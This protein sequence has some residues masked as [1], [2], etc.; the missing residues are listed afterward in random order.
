[1]FLLNNQYL[2]IVPAMVLIFSCMLLGQNATTPGS[3][4]APY[5]TITNLAV[6][7]LIS[8]DDNY[9]ATCTVKFRKSGSQ[10]WRDGMP[11]KRVAAG[12][13]EDTDPI[14]SWRNKFSGTIF[15]LQPGSSYEIKLALRDPDGGAVDTTITASTRPVPRTTGA[16]EIID[17]PDGNNG[18]LTITTDG[19]PG[20][21]KVYRSVSH[22]AVYSTIS[23]NNRKWV[24]LEGLTVNGSIN[25]R[26]AE[27]CAVKRCSVT[28]S[29]T[30]NGHG[31]ID[32]QLGITNCY[33]ADNYVLGPVQWIASEMG[34]SGASMVEGIEITGCG[35][36]IRNNYVKGFHDCLSHMED[37]EVSSDGQICNDWC[38]ND[39]FSG[40]D[41]GI[42]ADF[43][44]SN[45]RIIANRFTNCFNV[46]SSQPGLGGPTYFIRN[47]VFNSAMGAFKLNRA[48]V[49]DVI[50]HNSIVKAGDGL[51]TFDDTPFD[52]AIWENNLA[53]GGTNG[54]WTGS[55]VTG[56]YGPGSG[57]ACAIKACGSHCIF[58]Y[59][60]V[61]TY[62]TTFTARINAKD[63]F[64]VEPHGRRIDSAAFADF[65]FP[66]PPAPGPT[67]YYQPQDLRPSPACTSMV[68]KALLIPNINDDFLGA[69]PDIG[70]Y[71]AGQE[72]PVYG[73]R[74]EGV[75]EQTPF[76]GN[77]IT[78]P[79][80]NRTPRPISMN[81]HISPDASIR[82]IRISISS[83]LSGAL[84]SVFITDASG[85]R[86]KNLFSG[87]NRPV[88][89]L[90]WN[91]ENSAGQRLSPGAYF[92]CLAAGRD[93]HVQRILLCR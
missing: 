60:A 39:V 7:W 80:L 74:P 71:E 31:A 55:Q 87:V 88:V 86:V 53:L 5:P 81:V 50:L 22:K 33:I 20:R 48:S 68:D 90:E 25:M 13:S 64:T 15:N 62:K 46:M 61:G 63:F 78:A 84:M 17:V 47:V 57:Y 9:N 19:T 54:G 16:C 59:D 2:S 66:S 49:G 40:L 37:D 1:M 76:D 8:G 41:D 69:G 92:L 28:V 36:V 73:P 82:P 42:E 65:K 27:N 85:R 52:W 10:A 11:L 77:S 45:C 23:L 89:S 3:L 44:F 29:F 32:G 75:D 58:D 18:S 79:K 51:C 34:A 83:G 4:S 93:K 56:G 67:Y 30:G 91:G 24:Y 14:Y 6:E 12:E 70:A 21:P 72:L 38:G 35:N 43:A 26:E